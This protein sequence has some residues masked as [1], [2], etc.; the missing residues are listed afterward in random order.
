MLYF[1]SILHQ[2]TTI[3]GG[4]MT[5]VSCISYQ[6]YIKPQHIL[7][8]RCA[9]VCCISYQFYIKPQLATHRWLRVS[10]VFPIN[11]TSNHN[12][13]EEVAIA[14]E[15]YFLSILHQTTTRC[16]HSNFFGCCIS[17]QFYIKP[18]PAGTWCVELLVVFP[19]NS[20]SNHN[21]YA[22]ASVSY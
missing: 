8:Q 17:Y 5:L 11:S 14:N 18:Q 6:F 1:L 20:T 16:V 7:V 2:T 22:R 15:L 19:I 9:R 10:V 13:C 12:R 3:E 21:S 4:I